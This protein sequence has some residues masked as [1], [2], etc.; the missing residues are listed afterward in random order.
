M[1]LE[2][3]S[4]HTEEKAERKKHDTS[5]S[6]KLSGRWEE[7]EVLIQQCQKQSNEND[8]THWKPG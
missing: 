5:K 4:I 7:K 3:E 2:M 6:W 1:Q 8:Y